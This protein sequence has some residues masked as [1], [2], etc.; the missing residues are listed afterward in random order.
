MKNKKIIFTVA[1]YVLTNLLP[2][3]GTK[4]DCQ[5]IQVQNSYMYLKEK[6]LDKAKAAADASVVH[7]NTQG[8]AKAWLHRGMVYQAIHQDTSLK[9]NQL[10]AE[11]SE[12]AVES[13]IRCLELDKNK[14]YKDDVKG[15]LSTSASGLL[16]KVEK[17]YIPAQ[18]YDKA[19]AGC[20]LLKKVLPYDSDE[21]LKRRNVTSENITYIEYRAYYAA[22][23]VSKVRE[24]GDKLIAINFKMPLIYSSLAKTCLAQKD[25]AS[26]LSYL[27][28]GLA[29]FDDNMD[30][31]TMQIDILMMQKKND[32]LRKKLETAVELSP[33]SDVL[34]SVL[35]NLYSK[36]NELDKAEK[37]Y[38]KA[39]EIN[40]K[41]EYTLFNLGALYFNAGNDW[42][43]KFND[44]PPKETTKAKEYEAKSDSNFKSAIIYFEQYYALKPDAAVK[45]RLRKIYAL[46]GETEKAEKYK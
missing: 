18:Q 33:D 12:K 17:Y 42:N 45:Q 35:A 10:D 27:D 7:E 11:A 22:N 30:L 4:G 26:A 40:P 34:H 21:L 44:L 14:V 5:N 29:L 16:N 1:L 25:T 37:E 46:L 39:V 20:D 24:I 9:V 15:G 8:V 31:L 38:L 23:N 41:S 43:K 13:Y 32:L 2:F 36:L 19:T 28:K 6:R 3:G